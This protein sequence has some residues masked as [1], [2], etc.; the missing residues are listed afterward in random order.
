[1]CRV[2]RLESLGTRIREC[3]TVYFRERLVCTHTERT[4]RRMAYW[5]NTYRAA[6]HPILWPYLRL[7]RAHP[8]YMN[9]DS[10]G[11]R[12]GSA[13][14]GFFLAVPIEFCSITISHSDRILHRPF[15][16]CPSRF[17]PGRHLPQISAE[18]QLKPYLVLHI[19]LLVSQR[20]RSALGILLLRREFWKGKMGTISEPV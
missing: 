18:T 7:R 16:I 2:E 17:L 12:L 15:G 9:G 5:T 20:G 1:M 13:P 19:F 8:E 10:P 4:S 3:G 11:F 6:D 14:V